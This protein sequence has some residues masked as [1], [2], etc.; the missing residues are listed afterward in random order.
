M[1]WLNQPPAIFQAI[2]AAQSDLNLERF[3]DLS[4]KIRKTH[5]PVPA[6]LVLVSAKDSEISLLA[7]QVKN[8]TVQVVQLPRLH[9]PRSYSRKPFLRP[10]L[11]NSSSSEIESGQCWYYLNFGAKAKKCKPGC[12]FNNNTD[13]RRASPSLAVCFTPQQEDFRHRQLFQNHFLNR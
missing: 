11:C 7:K 1:L 10:A 2:L 4:D 9:R 13:S 12:T 6:Q 8:L 3:A 5:T